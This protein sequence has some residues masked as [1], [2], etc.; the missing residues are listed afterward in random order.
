[1]VEGD[2]HTI[3]GRKKYFAGNQLSMM[4]ILASFAIVQIKHGQSQA[5]LPDMHIL[6]QLFVYM[7]HCGFLDD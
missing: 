6:I 3:A 5:G 4:S 2:L 7:V 1:M